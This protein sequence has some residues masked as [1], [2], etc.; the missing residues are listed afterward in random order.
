M[1]G[2]FRD[3]E[4]G[5]ALEDDEWT[6]PEDR[7]PARDRLLAKKNAERAYRE[8]NR[9]NAKAAKGAGAGAPGKP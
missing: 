8:A 2:V 7:D 3:D 4:D 1:P 5:E 6:D 9:H